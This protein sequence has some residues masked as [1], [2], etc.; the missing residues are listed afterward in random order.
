MGTWA[1]AILLEGVGFVANA[2]QTP[3]TLTGM[4]QI[5]TVVPVVGFLA[6]AVVIMF[7]PFSTADHRKMVAELAARRSG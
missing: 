6:S 1:L 2:D 3:E 4:R 5:M 7:F